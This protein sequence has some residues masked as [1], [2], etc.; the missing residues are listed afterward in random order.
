MSKELHHPSSL[1]TYA[2]GLMSPAT[3]GGW[4]SRPSIQALEVIKSTRPENVFLC[5][6]PL[7]IYS[8]FRFQTSTE[9]NSISEKLQTPRVCVI[10]CMT[11]SLENAERPEPGN[12]T[13]QVLK[14]PLI[15]TVVMDPVSAHKHTQLE[16][17]LKIKPPH[18]E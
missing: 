7:Y 14:A 5:M 4:N 3:G 8:H 10:T 11:P 13:Q 12:D 17:K 6:L 9:S 1:I 16:I 15:V 18:P 2:S